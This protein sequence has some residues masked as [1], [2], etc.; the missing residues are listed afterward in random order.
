MR[1]GLNQPCDLVKCRPG[2]FCGTGTQ[3][4][5]IPFGEAFSAMEGDACSVDSSDDTIVRCGA[6]SICSIVS[7][8]SEVS[9]GRCVLRPGEEEVCSPAAIAPEFWCRSGFYCAD[10]EALASG[11][12]GSC[13][14]LPDHG[15]P[16]GLHFGAP[17]F[18]RPGLRC[19]SGQCRRLVSAGRV[20]GSD[21]G[22]AVGRC[23]D[24]LCTLQCANT[25]I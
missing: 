21:E 18:C 17:R 25:E 4:I 16:C 11:G 1:A 12:A 13:A 10:L 2:L 7:P 20:C 3:R 19:E 24:G 8:E 23:V 14:Q 22:C 15:E 5:C 6:G 9:S